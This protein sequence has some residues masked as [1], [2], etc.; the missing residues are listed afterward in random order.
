MSRERRQGGRGEV[1]LSSVLV[2]DLSASC[3]V[4]RCSLGR[5]SAD[6]EVIWLYGKLCL[7][8]DNVMLKKA[9]YTGSFSFPGNADDSMT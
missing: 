2:K 4:I 5:S 3:K 6:Y 8:A 7:M 9:V 1:G